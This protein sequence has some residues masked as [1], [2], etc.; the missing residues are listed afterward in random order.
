LGRLTKDEVQRTAANS[1][2]LPDLQRRDG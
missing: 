2:K 1:A